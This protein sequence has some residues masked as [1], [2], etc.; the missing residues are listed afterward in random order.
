MFVL[1]FPY[2][3]VTTYTDFIKK[4]PILSK[5]AKYD[6]QAF[7]N[8]YIHKF[9]IDSSRNCLTL[10][11]ST[12]NSCH[13]LFQTGLICVLYN[14]F[15][16]QYILCSL[17]STKQYYD[18][19]GASLYNKV[20][21]P[22]NKPYKRLLSW[23]ARYCG[24]ENQ[25]FMNTEF[26]TQLCHITQLM[27]SQSYC[28]NKDIQKGQINLTE[29]V[30]DL[31]SVENSIKQRINLQK[32]HENDYN[33]PLLFYDEH[34]YSLTHSSSSDC[35]DV[36]SDDSN[37]FDTNSDSNSDS[38]SVCCEFGFVCDDSNIN[39]NNIAHN[40]NDND[41]KVNT[42]NIMKRKIDK[43]TSNMKVA[44]DESI[45]IDDCIVVETTNISVRKKSVIL[46]KLDN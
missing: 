21:K 36:N 25:L 10:C 3:F 6:Y 42:T 23:H 30:T 33:I 12:S 31:S 26:S 41:T 14:P 45:C 17:N 18:I 35:S 44:S 38:N 22:H 15:L 19:H 34:T 20:I 27:D 29:T 2:L 28:R 9:D 24:L 43:I 5:N 46:I 13:S 7:H 32:Q 16:Q 11:D 4:V 8:N 1:S 40:N 37:S 39:N